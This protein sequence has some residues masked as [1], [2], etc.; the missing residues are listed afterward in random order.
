MRHRFLHGFFPALSCALILLSYLTLRAGTTGKIAGT[1]IDRATRA[2]LPGVNLVLEGTT[3][4]AVSDLNGQYAIINIAPGSYTL[5]ASMMGYSQSRITEIRVRADMTQSILVTL[6]QTVIDAGEAVTVVAQRPLVELDMTSSLASVGSDEIASLPVQSIADVLELQAGIVSSGSGLHI[7]GGRAGEVIYWVDGVA[8]TDV[9]SGGAGVTVENAAVEELQVVSGTFNAEYGNAMSGIVNI[10]TKEGGSAW[11]GQV[12]TWLGDYV[13]GD[14]RFRILNSVQATRDPATGAEVAVADYDYPLS[15]LN[16]LYNGEVSL[17]GPL[18]LSSDKVSFFLNSRYVDREGYLYGRQWFTPQGNQGDSSLVPLSP[19]WQWTAQ[20]KVTARLRN[21]L[22]MSYNLFYNTW[23]NDRIYN[24]AYTYVPES[25]RQQLGGGLTQILTINH[26]LSPKTF[27]ELRLNRFYNEYETYLYADPTAAPRYLVSVANDPVLGITA[28]IFNPATESGAAELAWLKEN[29]AQFQ[30]II[31]PAGPAGY[32]HPDSSQVPAAYS[33]QNKGTD[34]WNQSRSTAYWVGKLDLTSQITPVHQIKTGLEFRRYQLKLDQFTIRPALNKTG[35]EQLVPFVP[36][37]PDISSIYHEKYDRRP[38]EVS[39]YLQD[40]IELKEIILNLGLR[41]DYFDARGV[42]PADPSDPDIY[43]P[44]K[45]EHIYKNWREP[46]APLAGTALEA[47]RAGFSKYTP[48]ERRAFMH[49]SVKAKQ[50]VSPR[51]GIAY[52]VT[53]K[54]VIHFSYGHFFQIPEFQYL[55][56]RPD[57]KLTG[58]SGY[59]IFGN[60]DLDAQKTVMYEIGLKQE[61]TRDVGIDVTVF[62]RDVRDWVGTSPL[63]DTRIPSVKYARFENKDYENVRGVTLKLEKRMAD[64]Y[65][66]RLDYAYQIAEGTYSNPADA[67]NALASNQEPRITLIPMN[68][69]QNHTLNGSF[70]YSLKEWTLSL[71]GRYWTG[72]P[73]T[74]SFARGEKVGSASRTG[75]MENSARLPEQKSLD[76]YVNRQIMVGRMRLEFFI[77]VYNLLDQRDE[78]GVYSDTGT[79][80]YTTSVDVDR[81]PYNSSRVGTVADYVNQ[82]AWYTA[83]REVQIGFILGF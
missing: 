3:L 62:Y 25:Q 24:K 43:R 70:I 34:L 74:P 68:W 40:K 65:A 13:S 47:Y 33:F 78:T 69:D 73:Y 57:F 8:A 50:Q 56:D 49:K 42:V 46:E 27:Y 26:V 31:D 19:W 41:F 63:F 72:R 30:Y 28:H 4:G 10:I 53:D 38:L 6:T 60:A 82:P 17:S 54:G 64:N 45:D 1:V 81:I 61:L 35:E 21:S 2:P 5:R 37:V 80:E 16:P 20:G 44:M 58:G 77:N 29:R 55:Y 14:D 51:L 59:T 15:R 7:R 71:I 36:E 12:K 83:P 32:I 11:A 22:K 52:P 76:L 79:A 66:A 67:Y 9:F 18:P 48:E 23:K 75:L 39:A